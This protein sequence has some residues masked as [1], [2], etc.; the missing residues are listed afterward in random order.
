MKPRPKELLGRTMKVKT[1]CGSLF[2]TVNF[3]ESNKPFEVFAYLGKSGSCFRSQID[4]L[5]RIISIALRNDTP[6]EDIIEHLKG[7]RCP[8]PIITEGIE[9]LSCA[10]AI[11]K[12][13][14]MIVTEV[15]DVSQNQDR[16]QPT[17]PVENVQG[18]DNQSV[19]CSVQEQMSKEVVE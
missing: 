14:E 13:M 4:S 18:I 17:E 7:Q 11:A 19:C 1:G 5:C 8:S 10:D 6:A 2:V 12:V 15:N 16:P 9:F 3:D